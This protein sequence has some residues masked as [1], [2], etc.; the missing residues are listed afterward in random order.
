VDYPRHRDRRTL[1]DGEDFRTQREA[2]AE[3]L[4]TDTLRRLIAA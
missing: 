4:A 1:F 2:I 3:T